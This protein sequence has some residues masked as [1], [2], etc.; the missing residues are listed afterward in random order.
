MLHLGFRALLAEGRRFQLCTPPPVCVAT[1]LRVVVALQVAALAQA[2]L[3]PAAFLGAPRRVMDE[4]FAYQFAAASGCEEARAGNATRKTPQKTHGSNVS[5]YT[6]V[7]EPEK[8]QASE[9]ACGLAAAEAYLDS[10]GFGPAER[11]ALQAA[12]LLPA[13][14]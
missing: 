5:G 13:C 7:D 12:L 14:A 6:G 9:L 11:G 1:P 4:A 10:I 2:H 3:D 8:A